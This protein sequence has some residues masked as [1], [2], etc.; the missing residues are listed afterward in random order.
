MHTGWRGLPNNGFLSPVPEDPKYRS[1]LGLG[2]GGGGY[3]LLSVWLSVFP[4]LVLN[5]SAKYSLWAKSG[6]LPIS[7][8]KVLLE[9]RH[10]FVY[11]LSTAALI[12][13]SRVE[14]LQQRFIV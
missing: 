2:P 12:L 6:P 11:I 1:L 7:V 5:R 9:H 8:N 3:L 14:W 13:Q 10:S 4:F